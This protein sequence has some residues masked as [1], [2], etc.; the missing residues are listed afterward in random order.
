M[1][2]ITEFEAAI[3]EYLKVQPEQIIVVNSGSSA[4]FVVAKHLV[5]YPGSKVVTSP[6]TF[7]ATVNAIILAGGA[8]VFVDTLPDSHVIDIYS[9][10]NWSRYYGDCPIIYPTLFQTEMVGVE[11]FMGPL[12]EDAA[13]SFFPSD[14]RKATADYATFSFYK[15]KRLSTYEGG[16]IFCRN[17]AKAEEIRSF[18]NHG[19][20]DNEHK[21][22]G[23]NFRMAEPLAQIGLDSL[24]QRRFNL[25]EKQ[26]SDGY[27]P[28]LVCDLPY[29]KQYE[30][31]NTGV[32]NARR[33]AASIRENRQPIG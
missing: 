25:T 32:P 31:V 15:T 27:Y 9:A 13:Q 11:R 24:R 5:I 2:V 19:R 20:V 28:Y 14:I 4:L 23:F 16:A 12:C 3:A 8:P 30:R 10:M 7:P 18:I 17:L 29:M 26:M 22:L 6:F 1:S 33:L 21:M